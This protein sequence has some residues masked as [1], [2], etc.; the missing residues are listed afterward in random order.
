VQNCQA[1]RIH[2]Q[3]FGFYQFELKPGGQQPGC[4][5]SRVNDG[6]KII[7][8]QLSNGGVHSDA[9]RFRPGYR[10]LTRQSENPRADFTEQSELGS[11]GDKVFAGHIAAHR[12]MPTQQGFEAG[13]PMG[14]QVNLR[15]VG[16]LES[17]GGPDL[18]KVVLQR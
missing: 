9:K 13:N 10:L 3:Y 12:M 5:Q 1:S 11:Q 15:L 17:P 14:H 8:T 6:W 16:K 7:V 4:L 2:W 18:S